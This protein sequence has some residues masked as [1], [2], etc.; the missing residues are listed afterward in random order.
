MND[1]TLDPR[2]LDF[3]AEGPT[4]APADA[5]D[6][7]VE[8]V[9]A[10]PRIARCSGSGD[11]PSA[12]IRPSSPWLPWSCW[13]C[14]GWYSG[15]RSPTCS[16]RPRARPRCWHRSPR[17]GRSSRRR[18]APPTRPSRTLV[19]TLPDDEAFVLAASCTGGGQVALEV[20]NP[21][22][23]Y[24]PGEEVQPERR[25][26]VPCDGSA[27]TMPFQTFGERGSDRALNL[28][29]AADAGTTWRVEVGQMRSLPAAP[30]FEGAQ[31][32]DGEV[33]LLEFSEGQLVAG[34]VIQRARRRH[35]IERPRSS[36]TSRAWAIRSRS[37]WTTTQA[38]RGASRSG[39]WPVAPP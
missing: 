16:R 39:A 1:L 9:A 5:F 22:V 24:A 4:R 8:R 3:L 6:A 11:D 15:T 18:A 28:E 7:I 14:P 32:R 12:S 10:A 25:L 34:P 26:D 17:P 29:V 27:S 20:I 19:G 23:S 13:P 37:T 35:A 33:V 38:R 21:D 2:A 31:P 30:T 36:S